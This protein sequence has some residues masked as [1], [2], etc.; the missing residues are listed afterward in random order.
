MLRDGFETPPLSGAGRRRCFPTSTDALL[1]A[2]LTRYPPSYILWNAG[3]AAGVIWE[4][5]THRA[6]AGYASFI[7]YRALE[8]EWREYRFLRASAPQ[9]TRV[10]AVLRINSIALIYFAL[11]FYISHAA[12]ELFIRVIITVSRYSFACPF[13]VF[14]SAKRA[15]TSIK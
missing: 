4:L 7:I 6:R 12:S 13:G 15:I 3:R 2:T 5:G 10:S 11:L 9:S 8:Y 14:P 1:L